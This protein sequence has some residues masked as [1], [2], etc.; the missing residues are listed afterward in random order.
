MKTYILFV[1]IIFGTLQLA[2]QNSLVITPG[3]SITVTGNTPITLQNMNFVNNG[4]FTAG[5]GMVLFKGNTAASIGGSGT[6]NFFDLMINNSGGVTLECNIGI[7]NQLNMSGMMN[8][9]TNSIAL[10]N[11][12][13]IIN[14]SETNRL[15]TDAGNT[16][17][18]A[19]ARNFSGP[20]TNT[21]PANIGVEFV[22]AP[23][24]GNTTISRYCAAFIRNGSSVGLLKRYYNIQAANN[25]A[26]NATVRFYYFDSELNGVDENAAVLWKSTDNGISWNQLLPDLRNTT[27]NYLQKN[28]VNDFSLWTMGAVSSALPVVLSA[29][30][31]SCTNDGALLVW[32]T[33]L[34]E[35][36]KEFVIEKSTDG[37]N[38][39]S[40]GT[41]NANGIASDYHFTD[42]EAGIAYYR[43]KQVDKNGAF[44][45]S[46]IL[47][48]NCDVKSITLLLYPNPANEFTDLVFKSTKAFSTSI[49]LFGSNG[50]LV[51]SISTKVQVGTNTI[52]INLLGLATGTYLLKLEDG[53]VSIRKQFIKD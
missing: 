2:A 17:S 15:V 8:V 21:N 38:W 31:T 16:G 28:N 9:K 20:L 14:E 50:Q 42:A 29:Y 5:N 39:K 51:K 24:L 3:A 26:L 11:G 4:I 30:N 49:Q 25:T 32:T 37:F 48:S 19:V 6:T 22:N 53:S 35:N 43:L 52:R 10:T 1:V 23:A 40:I 47:R 7:N 36:S 27:A 45:Y 12:A 34:E 44:V 41:I 33:Q 18:V 13:S 46:R